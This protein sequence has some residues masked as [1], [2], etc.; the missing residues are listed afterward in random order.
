[1]N[2][3][4]PITTKSKPQRKKAHAQLTFMAL[5]KF[6]VAFELELRNKPREREGGGGHGEKVREW[7]KL[8]AG[9]GILGQHC[10]YE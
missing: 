1:M 5:V 9:A 7:R 4:D 10:E 3:C 2:N 6:S 8:V